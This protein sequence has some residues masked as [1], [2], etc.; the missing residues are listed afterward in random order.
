MS[1][2]FSIGDFVLLVDIAHKTYRNCQQAGDEYV[3]IANAVHCLHIVLRTLRAEAERPESKIFKQNPDSIAQLLQTAADCRNVLDSLDYILAKYEGLKIDSQA[4]LGKKLWQR[5]RFGSKIEELMSIRSKLITYTSTLSILLDT[6]HIQAADRLEIKIEGGLTDLGG[7]F[8][9]MRKEIFEIATQ[10]RREERKGANMSTLS[11]STYAGD[12]RVVWQD[13]RRELVKKGFK[14]Q[15]LEKNKHVLLAYMTKLDQSRLLDQKDGAFDKNT[16]NPWWAKKMFSDT[17]SSLA[18]LQFT[19]EPLSKVESSRA[20]IEKLQP[21]PTIDEGVGVERTKTPGETAPHQKDGLRPAKPESNLRLQ[22]ELQASNPTE[23]EH[24]REDK[25]ATT[26][27]IPKDA[28]Y[29]LKQPTV[30]RSQK[31]RYQATYFYENLRENQSARAY[32][33]FQP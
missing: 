11:L 2:G 30:S 17:V 18:D 19:E 4:G 32:R 20:A 27:L 14:S 12:D 29:T 16:A 15:S 24:I 1:F 5:F 13:F 25:S 22:Q 10:A 31:F 21:M 23:E 8:E 26:H 3:E 33:S 9:K 6:L 28:N 7:K